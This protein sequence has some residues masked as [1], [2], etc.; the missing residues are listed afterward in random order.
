MVLG[1]PILLAPIMSD[2]LV[3]ASHASGCL[4]RPACALQYDKGRCVAGLDAIHNI[5]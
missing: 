4:L 5:T 1:I 2:I 3:V